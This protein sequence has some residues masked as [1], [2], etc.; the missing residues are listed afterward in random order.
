MTVHRNAPYSAHV[1]A[2][3]HPTILCIPLAVDQGQ[4][5]LTLVAY[6]LV[7]W[8]CISDAPMNIIMYTTYIM[9]LGSLGTVCCM[10]W[11]ALMFSRLFVWVVVL[12]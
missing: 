1:L 2:Q 4:P 6:Q 10:W 9:V 8:T 3:T 12:A 7:C 5:E 11:S